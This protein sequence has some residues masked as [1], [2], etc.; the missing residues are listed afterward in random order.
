MKRTGTPRVIAARTRYRE[1]CARFGLV[2][3]DELARARQLEALDLLQLAIADDVDG[4]LR[5]R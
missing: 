1:D 5:R 2:R 3:A 4:H